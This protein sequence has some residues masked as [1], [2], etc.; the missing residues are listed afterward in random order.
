MN[1]DL[2]KCWR[3]FFR[4]PFKKSIT[5]TNQVNKGTWRRCIKHWKF[6]SIWTTCPETKL[7]TS[8]LFSFNVMEILT[9]RWSNCKTN[10]KHLKYLLP[11]WVWRDNCFGGVCIGRDKA[12]LWVN[13]L[14]V[15]IGRGKAFLW[16]YLLAMFSSD[17]SIGVSH[18]LQQLL[19]FHLLDSGTLH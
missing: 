14:T 2:Q 3:I 9:C 13:L 15:C 1:C 12:F 4:A 6:I 10:A 8:S 19:T 5:K 18:W 11:R 17:Q 7:L 16:I